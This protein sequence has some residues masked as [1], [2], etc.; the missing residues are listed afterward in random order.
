MTFLLKC[1]NSN[2]LFKN[3]TTFLKNLRI[4]NLGKLL[5]RGM[6]LLKRTP[7]SWTRLHYAGWSRAS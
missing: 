6:I 7:T 5:Q 4:T 2:T 1:Y 3:L